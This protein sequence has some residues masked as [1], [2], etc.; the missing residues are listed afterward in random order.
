MRPSGELVQAG[1]LLGLSFGFALCGVQE[2]AAA[3]HWMW[4]AG[5]IL[6]AAVMV[7]LYCWIALA[8]V[9]LII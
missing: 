6:G 2:A 9:K 7:A 1:I 4:M 3:R 5:F 8:W